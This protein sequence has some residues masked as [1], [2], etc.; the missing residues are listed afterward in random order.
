MW[1]REGM[2]RFARVVFPH[3]ELNRVYRFDTE[4]VAFEPP[5]GVVLAP[6]DDRRA[7]EAS[8]D[9]TIRAHGWYAGDHAHGFGLWTNGHLLAMT[10]F[11]TRG[12]PGLPSWF[13]TLREDE[14]VM[15]DLITSPVCRGHGY[16]SVLTNYSASELRKR[17]YRRLWTFVW[18]SNTPSIRSFEKAAWTYDHFLVQVQPFWSR[19]AVSFRLNRSAARKSSSGS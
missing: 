16:A 7:V 1:L 17:G 2:K 6:L 14:A 10:W 15:I 19:R 11:W 12:R 13:A 8:A 3:Y 5:Q 18:H 9:E 4:R